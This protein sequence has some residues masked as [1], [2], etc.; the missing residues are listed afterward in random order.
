MNKK[1]SLF[2]FFLLSISLQAQLPINIAKLYSI[3]TPK[4]T[5]NF[6]KFDTD[7]TTTK[8]TILFCQGS[9]PIPLIVT[10]NKGKSFVTSINNFD[11]KTY[12]HI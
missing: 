10:D 3:I 4:D 11:Y 1:L 2:L 9:L 8:P 6:I 7:T 12:T 5:I